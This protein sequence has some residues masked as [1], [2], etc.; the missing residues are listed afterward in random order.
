MPSRVVSGSDDE[1]EIN[2]AEMRRRMAKVAANPPVML[3]GFCGWRGF[4]TGLMLSSWPTVLVRDGETGQWDEALSE[5]GTF[6]CPRCGHERAEPQGGPWLGFGV[7][8]R[9]AD[10]TAEQLRDFAEYLGHAG[11]D[12]SPEQVATEFPALARLVHAMAQWSPDRWVA[13]LSLLVSILSLGHDIVSDAPSP[14]PQVRVVVNQ[15]APIVID[16][17]G[18]LTDSQMDELVRRLRAADEAA[19]EHEHEHE[20]DEDHGDVEEAGGHHGDVEHDAKADSGHDQ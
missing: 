15:P 10:L 6:T 20:L 11:P 3:C 1:P 8:L 19:H 17:T 13:L 5:G 14:A 9:D 16:R 18:R 12:V 4:A 2:E 7:S